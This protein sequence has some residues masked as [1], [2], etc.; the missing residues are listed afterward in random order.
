MAEAMHCLECDKDFKPGDWQCLPGIQHR[1]PAER[2][3]MDDAPTVP[4]WRDGRPFINKG[5]SRTQILNIPP[6]KQIREGEQV[7]RIPGGSIEFVR[8]MYETEDPEIQFYLDRKQGLVTEARW[9][10]VYLNDD[11]KLQMSKLELAARE[12]RVAEREN[13]LLT[14]VKSKARE[15]AKATA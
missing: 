8:G 11:E 4:E 15:Q 12:Q 7:T 2:Y 9:R 6:E 5:A 1:V 14:A 10:E 13:E 3:Y